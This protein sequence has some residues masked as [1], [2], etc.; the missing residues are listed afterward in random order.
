MSNLQPGQMLG[1]YRIINQIGQGGMATVYK[2]YQASMDRNV[3]IKVLPGELAK[4]QEFAKRFQQEAHII[5][6]LEHAHILPVF[7]YGESDGISYFVMRYLQAGTLKD[8]MEA[9]R[10]LPLDEIDRI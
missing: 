5:A 2:A 8:R 4:S 6:K 1:P 10:P 7:D 9:G 3:A